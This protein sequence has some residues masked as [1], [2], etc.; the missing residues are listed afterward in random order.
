MTTQQA[1][2]DRRRILYATGVTLFTGTTLAGCLDEEDTDDEQFVE[3]EPDYG[4]WFDD[5][6]NYEGTVDL[7]GEDEVEVEVGA[8]DDGLL[9]EPPGILI[10]VGT[11]VVW[12]WTGEGGNHDV[13][14][15]E[16]PADLDSELTGEA[17]FTYEFTF[18]EDH[19]GPTKY[20]CSPHIDLGMKG[21][22]TVE[23]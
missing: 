12:E 18:E 3:D 15:E 14:T 13:T 11:T 16:G 23:D 6:D 19:Q 9:F 4:D 2:Y 5:V 10:D 21:A 20:Y 8:G 1:R 17:G 22:V 7:R